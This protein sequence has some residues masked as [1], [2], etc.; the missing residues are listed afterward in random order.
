M[1]GKQ[2]AIDA[3][4]SAGIVTRPE[5][6]LRRKELEEESAFYGAMDGARS[7]CAAMPLRALSPPASTCSAGIGIGT[8]R[9]GLPFGRCGHTFSFLTVGDGLV[10]RSRRCWSR[11][12]PV[13]W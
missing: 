5:A 12:P 11:S 1:P 6:R 4:L 13:S 3:D 2:M 8:L 9:H 7:S 10:G